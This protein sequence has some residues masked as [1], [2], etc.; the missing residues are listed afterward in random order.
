MSSFAGYAA[1]ITI[2]ER[3]FDDALLGAWQNGTINHSIS[4]S[5][6]G[7]PPSPRT[8]FS[9]FL[10]SPSATFVSFNR[11]DGTLKL[12]GRGTI[13]VRT[14]PFPFPPRELRS[15][16]WQADLLVTLTASSL[17][18]I[19]LLSGHK[20]QYRLIHPQFDSVSGPFSA[21][22]D[23]LL[24]SADFRDQF[25]TW[26]QDA[27]G[28]LNFPVIDFSFLGPFMGTSF[29]SIDVQCVAGALMLGFNIDV[30]GF[31]TTG[32]P[33]ALAD[34]AGSND[35]A[36]SVNPDA[37]G[38]L[39]SDA[40]AKVQQEIDQYGATLEGDLAITCEE[41]AFRVR[42]RASIT[43][44]AAN[45]SLAV[46][47]RM[48]FT[49]PGAIFQFVDPK[50][51][52]FVKGRAW[53][54]I[55]FAP[56]D[57]SVD[58]DRSDWVQVVE[59]VGGVL[60]LG[61]LPFAIE[62]IIA[63][64]ARNIT[65]GIETTDLT[66]LGVIPRVRRFG[67]P[68][69][70][71]K[72]E[73]F[74]VH[75]NGLFIA[76]SVRLEAPPGKLGGIRSIPRNFA[77]RTVRYEVRLPFAVLPD[78]PFL[79]IRWTVVEKHSG[80]SLLNSDDRAFGRLRFEFVPGAVG[81]HVDQ[82]VVSCRV[83]QASGTFTEDLLNEKIELDVGP[84]LKPGAFIRWHYYVKNPQVRLNQKTSTWSFAGEST[85]E[86]WS[87]FHRTDKPCNSVNNRS[88]FIYFT[89]VLDDIPFPL[90][91][92]NRNRYRLCDY[93]FFGGPAATIAKL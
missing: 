93:C 91:D 26:L 15:V 3:V 36:V 30:G 31:V 85:I 72:I 70:R 59:A 19:V 42:G 17:G 76:I 39:M 37:I 2:R 16:Q 61:F 58:I 34:F 7:A 45:F 63:E 18:T 86:R 83:Y 20:E 75:P 40:K 11:V 92:I 51:T 14:N 10:D 84:H 87:K 50:K 49:L 8:G 89:E 35:V 1:A 5:I 90:N 54:A 44:A 55:S 78:D 66:Y 60:T 43:G 4:R 48:S 22:T 33:G 74:A 81:P 23:A 29:T 52:P 38:P 12:K 9:L 80:V 28:N 41:G 68:P 27:I 57:V 46:V 62:S 32:I 25:Q 47:P 21:D 79:R 67:D 69:T 65:N 24:A 73:Q 71:F 13:V 88:R 77:G 56:A 53:L 64:T 6:E 82:F